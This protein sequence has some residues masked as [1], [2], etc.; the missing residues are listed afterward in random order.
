MGV[1]NM[2]KLQQIIR[3]DFIDD[4]EEQMR[5]EYKNALMSL[6]LLE[7]EAERELEDMGL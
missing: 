3:E 6:G 4:D 1:N 7:D 2:N 5:N